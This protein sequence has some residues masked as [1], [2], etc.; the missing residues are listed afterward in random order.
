VDRR[1]FISA[2]TVSLLAASVAVEAQT[3]A[4]TPRI[5]VLGVTPENPSLAEAFKQG[6]GEVG[7]TDGQNVAI[8]YRDGGLMAYGPSIHEAFWR[9]GTYAGRILQGAKPGVLPVERPTKFEL[10]INRKTAK[11]LGLTLPQSLL[12]RADRVI[13]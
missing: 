1:K 11:T 13:E 3:A 9:A 5:G 7:Y 6:L 8:E 12:Q 4:R 2:V 10:V